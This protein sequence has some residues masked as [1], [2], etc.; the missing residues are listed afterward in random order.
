MASKRISRLWSYYR[1]S[2]KF[3][4][5]IARALQEFFAEISFSE[6]LD[7]FFNE[8]LTFDFKLSSGLTLLED[9]YSRNPHKVPLYE[10]QI[11]KNL[12]DNVYGVLEVLRVDIDKGLEL[13]V[14]NTGEKYYVQERQA[15]FFLEKG[16]LFFNRIIK[17]D[18]HFE[19]IGA[20][21]FKIE[22][23]LESGLRK[24]L[25]DPKSKIDPK[26]A[27]SMLAGYAKNERK[28]FNLDY[29]LERIDEL[30]EKL[31]IS[32][33][34]NS[35][36]VYKW[37]S[38]FD[39]NNEYNSFAVAN[40]I[41]SLIEH[42]AKKLPVENELLALI[43]DIAN[44]TSNKKLGGKSPFEKLKELGDDYVP[45]FKPEIKKINNWEKHLEKATSKM[46]QRKME[47]ALDS[48]YELF[49]NLLDEEITPFYIYRVFANKAVCHQSLGELCLAQKTNDLALKLNK[50]YDFAIDVKER[51]KKH[52]K[53][54]LSSEDLASDL[55]ES[56][57]KEKHPYF[58]SIIKIMPKLSDKELLRL[59]HDILEEHEKDHW[60][61]DPSREYFNFLK[62]L[63]INFTTKN[64]TD[65]QRFDIK[66]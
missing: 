35:S 52:Q 38:D 24:L 6:E 43:S 2:P 32:E 23:N 19:L 12:Q 61:D 9:Y 56:L 66:M 63:G 54:R 14:L 11:Y 3:D 47:E 15:T 21:G 42:G 60:L 41:L 8:W 13:L 37:L 26:L 33:M 49:E 28:E 17:I 7:P 36:L 34:I 48:F 50:N 20:E 31:G 10:L 16:D 22:A 59:Y 51:I 1:N 45:S 25:K 4:D 5:E 58:K 53:H 27:A 62:K 29:S 39:F 18:D 64:L 40:I 30:L 65:S 55:R 44:N 57:P 46:G